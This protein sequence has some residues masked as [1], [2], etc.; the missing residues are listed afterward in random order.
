[1]LPEDPQAYLSNRP[2]PYYSAFPGTGNRGAAAPVPPADDVVDLAQLWGMV[3]DNYRLVL[4]I[5]S[6]LF[7]TV[8]AR[9]FA[10]PMM[11]RSV[12]RMYM[13][14]SAPG[15]QN[16]S[17]IDIN[18][19]SSEADSEI[20]VLRSRAMVR[21]G[22]LASGLNVSIT[23]P[24]WSPPR[25]LNWLLSDRDP[26]L[27][28][29]TT[30]VLRA[31]NT[32]LL[33]NILVPLDYEVRFVS[34]TKFLLMGDGETPV[35]GALGEGMTLS[36]GTL[37]LEGGPVAPKPGD[38]FIVVIEPVEDV[39]D[40]A[41]EHLAVSVPKS[42]VAPARVLLLEFVSPSRHLAASFLDQLMRGYLAARLEWKTENASAAESFVTEQMHALRASLDQSLAKLADYRAEN[43]VVATS[44]QAV[45]ASEQLGHFEKQ[46][47]TTELELSAL[48][49]IQ[50]SLRNPNLPAEAYM[51]GEEKDEVMQRLAASLTDARN[52]LSELRAEYS[53]SAPSVKQQQ[54]LV[55]AQLAAIGEYING[56]VQRSEKQL[57]A[58]NQVIGRA[59]EK[60]KSVPD[61]ELTLAQ[62]SR[63][64]EVYT[65][66][67]DDLLERKQQAAITKASTVSMDRI[68]DRPYVP[69]YEDSP[70]LLLHLASGPLGLLLG[71]LFVIVRGFFSAVFRRENDVKS[72][73]GPL[74]IIARIPT[75]V[76]SR[77]LEPKNTCP[78]FD[79]LGGRSDPAFAEA[80]RGLRTNLYR[81]L[82][83]E[84]GR[85]IM[86]TS[87]SSGDGKTT[88]TLAL[89][90]MLSADNRRVLVIDADVRNPSHHHEFAIPQEP[91]LQDALRHGHASWRDSVRSVCFSSG[92][93]DALS[94]GAS[95]RPELLSDPRLASLLVAV[96][97]HYDFVVLD[98]PSFPAVSDPLVL[99]PLADY[100]VSVVRL[101]ST[102][103]RTAEE[104][105]SG[106]F[107]VAR[108][109]S[110]IVNNADQITQV[111]RYGATASRRPEPVRRLR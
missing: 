15:A 42:G 20:E 56:R 43:S 9:C 35:P 101:G 72:V 60:L 94:V 30:N 81:A 14:E 111:Q 77:Q 73:L 12:A 61:A 29:A 32:Q 27:L 28:D 51:V 89:A 5:A 109:H 100:V 46:K 11:F 55:R 2:Q 84:H 6:L 93:F 50:R 87:P 22:V 105:L 10:A 24:G 1:M 44:N 53:D 76:R 47:I 91:G 39:V 58:I 4:L 69:L 57:A 108:G 40:W 7:V 96:R 102:S 38:E 97:S 75:R 67:Y 68:L 41:L 104:H 85:V 92:A 63:E 71:A 16:R 86:F 99:A 62:M 52:K 13:G 64:T 34:G 3:R 17:G 107:A 88:C 49:Q 79:V 98:S 106:M 83:G 23:P 31:T 8:M 54:S 19:G 66:L 110:V 45:A 33:E 48:R 90:A 18:T 65:R 21:K 70:R 25:Y 103:R 80:F 78:V 26:E 37:T 74:Q 95:P 82:P 36:T 59:E